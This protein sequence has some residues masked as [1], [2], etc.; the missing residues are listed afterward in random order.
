MESRGVRNTVTVKHPLPPPP[1]T[2]P[3]ATTKNGSTTTT[4][5][6]RRGGGNGHHGNLSLDTTTSSGSP[7]N[8]LQDGGGGGGSVSGISPAPEHGGEQQRASKIAAC[9]SCRRSKV[10]CEKGP[11]ASR[12]RKCAAANTECI[13]P[14]FNVGRR[15]GVKK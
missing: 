9:L 2:P 5:D 10:R 3:A 4:T 1:P 12:C 13:R 11:D 7:L 14:M 8:S 15:K 6:T